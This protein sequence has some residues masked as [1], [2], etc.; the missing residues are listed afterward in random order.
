MVIFPPLAPSARWFSIFIRELSVTNDL[1]QAIFN[2]NSIILSPKEF[3]RFYLSDHQGTRF[4]QTIAVEGGGRQMRSFDKIGTLILSEHGDW[5]RIHLGAFEANLGRKPFY[6]YL[7]DFL[8][9]VYTNRSLK[10]LEDFNSAIFKVCYSLLLGDIPP[11]SLSLLQS[12]I[13]M[14]RGKEIAERI[15]NEVSVLQV[16]AA[17]GREA[18]PGLFALK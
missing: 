14:E 12:G 16:L 5:R 10:R 3:G 7:Q 1:S 9:K 11:A 2:T 13:L 6:P 4:L 18:L 17:L 15:E 8:L